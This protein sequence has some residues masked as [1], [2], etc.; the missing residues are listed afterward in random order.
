VSTRR[1]TTATLAAGLLL[2]V[3]T[4]PAAADHLPGDGDNPATNANKCADAGGEFTG[5]STGVPDHTCVIEYAGGSVE[6]VDASHPRQAWKAEITTQ[7]GR[8]VY[9]FRPNTGGNP[10]GHVREG[11]G[12]PVQTGCFNHQGRSITDWETNPNCAPADS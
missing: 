8:D 3:L 2:G 6:L 4:V 7:G 5:P 11:G 1:F 10:H 12:D 9:T